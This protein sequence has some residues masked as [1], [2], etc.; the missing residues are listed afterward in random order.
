MN[1]FLQSRLVSEYGTLLVLLMLFAYYSA[2]TWGVI[3]PV[4]N[5]AA[6]EVAGKITGQKKGA[7]VV[8]VVG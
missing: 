4:G 7:R 1:N 8:I 6:R 3:H 5:S 2:A